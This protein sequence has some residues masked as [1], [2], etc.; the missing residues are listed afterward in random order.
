MSNDDL[1]VVKCYVDAS[2]VVQPYFKSHNGA[3]MTMRQGAMKS[4]SRKY[5]PNTR[6]SKQAELFAVDDVLVYIW[7]KVLLIEWQ[8]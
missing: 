7:W 6:I 5:K 8:G 1:K 2:F 4:A 3:I